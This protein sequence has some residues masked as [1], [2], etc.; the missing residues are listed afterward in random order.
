[1]SRKRIRERERESGKLKTFISMNKRNVK[2]VSIMLKDTYFSAFVP[3]ESASSKTKSSLEYHKSEISGSVKE[4][5]T[6]STIEMCYL[7]LKNS[8]TNT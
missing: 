2:Y 1:M 8:L 4:K 5:K 7:N 3:I 6:S